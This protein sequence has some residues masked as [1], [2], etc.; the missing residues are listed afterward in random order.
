[1]LQDLKN[2]YNK[3]KL[4][5]YTM[6]GLVN[7]IYENP[8]LY[9]EK[10]KDSNVIFKYFSVLSI[11]HF[12]IKDL[13]SFVEK[14]KQK[15]LDEIDGKYFE[16]HEEEYLDMYENDTDL[17]DL[18]IYSNILL[19]ISEG[20][21]NITKAIED[22]VEQINKKDLAMNQAFTN[23]FPTLPK[24]KE[25]NG[26]MIEVENDEVEAGI[27]SKAYTIQNYILDDHSILLE[28]IKLICESKGNVGKIIEII[29]GNYTC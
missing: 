28:K 18:T 6:K 4:E 2:T 17:N 5:V 8:E 12:Q 19:N 20:T 10:N 3:I 21:Y 16:K 11:A 29:D 15:C 1:M 27:L 14:L 24:Y 22:I 23:A 26:E 9:E 25:K 7:S 13:V